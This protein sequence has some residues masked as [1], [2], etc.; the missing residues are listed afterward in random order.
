MGG[1]IHG[2][3]GG[4]I[5]VGHSGAIFDYN[6]HRPS[7]LNMTWRAFRGELAQGEILVIGRD[8]TV[9]QL[10]AGPDVDRALRHGQSDPVKLRS[11]PG[12]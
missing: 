6:L 2:E 8:V 4:Q 7:G 1:L 9:E 3:P 5:W 10:T 12:H 11:G